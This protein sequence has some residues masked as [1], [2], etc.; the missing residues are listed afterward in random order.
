MCLSC[1][2]NPL[3]SLHSK[4]GKGLHSNA[5]ENVK[6]DDGH[7]NLMEEECMRLLRITS[8]RTHAPFDRHRNRDGN[9]ITSF[10]H[11]LVPYCI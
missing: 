5:E 10:K 3:L 9:S 1:W 7:A 4:L 6:L 8:C 2:C 11:F